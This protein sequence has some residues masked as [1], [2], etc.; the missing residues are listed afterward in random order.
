MTN[1]SL[2]L[3]FVLVI[4]NFYFFFCTK[5]II[6]EKE[7]KLKSCQIKLI[8]RKLTPILI[9]EDDTYTEISV[10]DMSDFKEGETYKTTIKKRVFVNPFYIYKG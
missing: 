3:S 5:L 9:W 6:Y 4:I 8:G 1:I 7:Q 10:K 2:L